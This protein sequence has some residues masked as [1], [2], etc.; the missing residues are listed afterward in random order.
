MP[1]YTQRAVAI[2]DAIV[3]NTAT[4]AQR[5]AILSAICPNVPVEWTQAQK[6][7]AF[8]KE[9]RQRILRARQDQLQKTSV[10]SAIAGAATQAATDIPETP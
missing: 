4:Q 9:I 6:A 2:C 1:T 8:I 5:D 10:D 3:N 7:E